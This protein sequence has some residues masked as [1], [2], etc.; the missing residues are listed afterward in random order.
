VKSVVACSGVVAC[1]PDVATDP[2]QP[3]EAEQL[4]AL[5][6][7]HMRVEEPPGDTVVGLALNVRS[8]GGAAVTVTVTV[9]PSVLAPVHIKVKLVLEVSGPVDS[10]PLVAF[11]PDQPSDASQ[12]VALVELQASVAACPAMIDCGIAFRETVV[13]G[14]ASTT[15]VMLW[16][17]VPPAPVQL[18]V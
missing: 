7:L 16:P 6:E 14:V 9:C 3:P 8:G 10:L 15:T 18:S 4:V 13:T 5:V 2:D 17:V 11:V 1:V 12:L